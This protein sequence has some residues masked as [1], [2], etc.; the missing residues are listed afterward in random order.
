M[1]NNVFVASTLANDPHTEG[2][3]QAGKIARLAGIDCVLLKPSIDLDAFCKA[4][5]EYQ[6]KYIGMSYRLSPVVACDEL[7]KAVEYLY[8]EGVVGKDDNVKIC[9]SGLPKTIEMLRDRVGHFPLKVILCEQYPEAID[10]VKETVE[11]FDIVK[12]IFG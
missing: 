6:P 2:M 8:N 5:K 9:F 10:R 11:F 7:E 12:H 4:I 1:R 3:H